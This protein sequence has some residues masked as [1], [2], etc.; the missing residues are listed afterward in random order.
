MSTSTEENQLN[1]QN[2]FITSSLGYHIHPTIVKALTEDAKL[3]PE[4]IRI[5][6]I[7]RGDQFNGS[8]SPDTLAQAKRVKLPFGGYSSTV[9]DLQGQ[10]DVVAVRLL[11][12]NLKSDRFNEALDELVALLKPGGWLQWIDWDPMTARIATVKAGAPDTVLRDVLNRFTDAL[13]AQK[14][15]STYK[16][17][18]AMSL[19]LEDEE[20]DMYTVTPEVRFTENVVAGALLY[21]E[22]SGHCTAEEASELR[23]KVKE[24]IESAGSLLFY[25]LWCHV[26]R[27]PANGAGDLEA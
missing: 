4:N 18:T 15:G 21:L 25:D 2:D 24:E 16:I 17:S 13:R 23:A 7:S 11:H 9:K 1:E 19:E 5:A 27:K 10:F 14:A 22:R 20:S 3:L 26:A 12:T 8:V 6:D